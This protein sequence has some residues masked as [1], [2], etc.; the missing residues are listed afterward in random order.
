MAELSGEDDDACSSSSWPHRLP[1]SPPSPAEIHW[2]DNEITI[3]QKKEE[4]ERNVC[5]LIG[6]WC[7]LYPH[8]Q[9]LRGSQEAA[10]VVLQSDCLLRQILPFVRH[11]KNLDGEVWQ[12]VWEQ[13]GEDPRHFRATNKMRKLVYPQTREDVCATQ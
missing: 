8:T 9:W 5:S 13:V 10:R 12:R 2:Q 11:V 3:V 7:W 4:A 6:Q 1:P